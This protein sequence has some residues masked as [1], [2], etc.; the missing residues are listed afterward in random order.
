VFKQYPS[1]GLEAVVRLN[2]ILAPVDKLSSPSAKSTSCLFW[3]LNSSTFCAQYDL[4]PVRSAPTK[5]KRPER[6]LIDYSTF[7]Y[8]SK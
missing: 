6:R 5:K 1:P 3:R 2:V 7:I 4:R 8:R